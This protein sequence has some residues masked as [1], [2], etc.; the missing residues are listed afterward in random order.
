MSQS[1]QT[2]RLY[3]LQYRPPW[4]GHWK[5]YMCSNKKASSNRL[6]LCVCCQKCLSKSFERQNKLICINKFPP[7][8]DTYL[9]I[10]Y[11]KV[12]MYPDYKYVQFILIIF[13][14]Q[15][16]QL[17]SGYNYHTSRNKIRMAKKRVKSNEANFFFM[18]LHF[19][20]F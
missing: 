12:S 11:Y 14:I 1:Q 8:L 16:C 20:K 13:W 15:I 3:P 7:N 6:P 18:K 17:Y 9:G 4:T 10:I 2:T 19:W 5:H